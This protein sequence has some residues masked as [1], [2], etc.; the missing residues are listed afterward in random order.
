[1]AQ[2][3]KEQQER[4]WKKEV[5]QNKKRNSV[6]DEMRKDWW[7]SHC[8]QL[9]ALAKEHS[10]FILFFLKLLPWSFHTP[11][12]SHHPPFCSSYSSW[13]YTKQ[14]PWFLKAASLTKSLG[15]CRRAFSFP[16]LLD[17]PERTDTFH[18]H[19][20]L[21]MLASSLTSV[22]LNATTSG[23]MDWHLFFMAQQFWLVTGLSVSKAVI[24]S[25]SLFCLKEF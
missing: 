23:F 1:M 21:S 9:R 3:L 16:L 6:E 2:A 15:L 7:S 17:L 11:F 19:T 13:Y 10:S 14:G 8:F 12:L 22:L 4:V 18:G 24:C 25:K 20:F 5:I